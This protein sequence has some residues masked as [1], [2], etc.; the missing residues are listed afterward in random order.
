MRGL[1]H[2]ALSVVGLAL[3][4]GVHCAASG[5]DDSASEGARGST[6]SGSTSSSSSSTGGGTSTSR[7]YSKV[8][9]QLGLELEWRPH[10]GPFSLT[11]A[12]LGFPPLDN[13]PAIAVERAAATYRFV[14]GKG[15]DVEGMIGVQFE[16]FRYEDSQRVPNHIEADL[17]PMLFVGIATRF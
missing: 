4:G 11:A 7:S 12:G 8:A 9:P 10:G 15:V 6:G 13:I 14:H 2:K 17:G 3:L 5:I 1:S 16:Q